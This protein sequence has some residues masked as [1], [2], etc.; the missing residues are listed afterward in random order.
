MERSHATTPPPLP[1]GRFGITVAS[2]WNGEPCDPDERVELWLEVRDEALRLDVDAP[3]HGDPAPSGPAAS[4][5]RLWEHEVVELM[6]LGDDDRYLEVELSPHGHFLVLMLHG[7]RQVT[8]QGMAM[9]YRATIADGRWRGEARI[10]MTWL[11][12]GCSRLNAYAIH[13]RGDARRHLAWRPPGGDQ[14]DFH[15][16]ERFAPLGSLV[17]S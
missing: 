6:L 3:F 17:T 1:P 7:A 9:H 15:R 16:L 10:P 11:P 12:P 13:G 14:P 5:P 2:T 4:T 8:H